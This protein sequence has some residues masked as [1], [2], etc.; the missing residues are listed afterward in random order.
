MA[1]LDELHLR[2]EARADRD[3]G[4]LWPLM[5]PVDVGAVHNGRELAAAHSQGG[6][7]GRETQH[8]LLEGRGGI[9]CSTANNLCSICVVHS[10]CMFH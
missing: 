4:L 3:E 5:E 9:E 2:E 7:H 8:Y 10:V 1:Y 6:A